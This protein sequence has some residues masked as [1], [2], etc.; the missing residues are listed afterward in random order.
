MNKS[1][2]ILVASSI[3]AATL[4]GTTTLALADEQTMPNQQMMQGQEQ[5]RG[6]PGSMPGY[7]HGNGMMGGGGYGQGNGM[8]QSGGCPM[9]GMMGG[10]GYGAGMMGGGMMGQGMGMMGGGMGGYGP[11]AGMMGGGMG[12]GYGMGPGMM[13][14]WAGGMGPMAMLNLSDAQTGQLEKIQS[15]VMKKQ[16]TLMRQIW[17][18]QEKLGDLFNADKRDPAAIGKAYGKV[19]ELQRQAL[20]TRI[21]AENKMAAVLTKE[22]K[23]QMRK[24]FSRGMMGY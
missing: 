18:E 14:G 19:S 11:G 21:D 23:N 15:E 22:Q 2:K 13:G 17:E 12:Q 3:V 9:G 10:G 8:Q 24:G 5:G 16:R 1:M 20:E 6:V 4:A 7:G